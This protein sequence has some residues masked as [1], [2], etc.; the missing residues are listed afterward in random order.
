ML[1]AERGLDGNDSGR[2]LLERT[3]IVRSGLSQRYLTC[4]FWLA[5]VRKMGAADSAGGRPQAHGG[6]T[7]VQATSDG[8]IPGSDGAFAAAARLGKDS[9]Q[10]VVHVKGLEVAMHD[11]R[12]MTR[13]LENYP[14]NPT[15]GDHTGGA[16]QKTSIRNTIG[17]CIFLGYDEPQTLELVRAATGWPLTSRRCGLWLA[18]V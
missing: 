1:G 2:S 10:Y 12:G 8:P 16:H 7:A 9:Q 5:V 14:V 6:Y 17:L 13:M 11:P 4:T 3:Q 18:A 15:G